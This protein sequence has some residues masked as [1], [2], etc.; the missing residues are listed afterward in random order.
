V[1]AAAVILDPARHPGLKIPSN[2][3]RR[4]AKSLQWRSVSI[5]WPGRSLADHEEIDRPEHP[6]GF[7][8]GHGPR[9]AALQLEP[10]E[11]QWMQ[12]LPQG[13]QPVTAI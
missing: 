3:L 8:A 4:D 7:L 13:P 2:S 6:A 10:H 5:R 9:V 1:V 11:V 12:P